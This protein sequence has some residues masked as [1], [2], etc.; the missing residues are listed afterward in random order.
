VFGIPSKTKIRDQTD[1]YRREDHAQHPKFFRALAGEGRLGRGEVA[2]AGEERESTEGDDWV[3]CG[4][5]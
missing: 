5:H 3:I 4:L 1:V 2:V